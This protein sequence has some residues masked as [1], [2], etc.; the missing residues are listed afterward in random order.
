MSTRL[1]IYQAS[2]SK[3]LRLLLLEECVNIMLQPGPFCMKLLTRC[4]SGV[5]QYALSYTA[6]EN[7][8]QVNIL[9][10]NLAIL[11]NSLK[12]FLVM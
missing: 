11:I 9:E 4:F 8:S 6:W 1:A 10:N 2:M 12:H 3:C 7:G 5:I